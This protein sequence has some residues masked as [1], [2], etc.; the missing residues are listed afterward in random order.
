MKAGPESK[1]EQN[2]QV[3]P[4]IIL[5]C[6]TSISPLGYPRGSVDRTIW[7]VNGDW[8]RPNLVHR[9]LGGC[10]TKIGLQHT[11]RPLN[12][13][14][15]EIVPLGRILMGVSDHPL[16]LERREAWEYIQEW[17]VWLASQELGRRNIIRLKQ[18]SLGKNHLDGPIV[19]GNELG[20]ILTST[21][22]SPPQRT[23]QKQAEWS[24][25]LTSA[26]LCSLATPGLG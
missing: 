22:E 13:S 8:R 2:E 1:R 6:C 9:S 4:Y 12:V 17:V 21:R 20:N 7:P 19:A 15:K 25:Q 18:G 16:C 24:L 3:N 5:Q 10:K 11:V 14:L 26:S 23:K